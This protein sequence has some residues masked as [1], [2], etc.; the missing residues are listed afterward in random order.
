MSLLLEL[1]M[2]KNLPE[3]Y[4]YSTFEAVLGLYIRVFHFHEDL[5]Y[6]YSFK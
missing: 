1:D 6:M 4:K 3:D 5:R 2:L